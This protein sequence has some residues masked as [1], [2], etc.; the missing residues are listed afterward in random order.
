MEFPE[1]AQMTVY[2]IVAGVRVPFVGPKVFFVETFSGEKGLRVPNARWRQAPR[3]MLEKCAE[4]AALR[5][6]FP[7]ELA[8]E[9]TAEEMAGQVL[10]ADSAVQAIY[11]EVNT[12]AGDA[13]GGDQA[14][15]GQQQGGGAEPED[16]RDLNGWH[17]KR[18][19]AYMESMRKGLPTIETLADL[20][21][22]L[23]VDADKIASLPAEEAKEAEDLI[24]IERER[25]EKLPVQQDNGLATDEARDE[26]DHSDEPPID[27]N[28]ADDDR[29]DDEPQGDGTTDGTDEGTPATEE[30]DEEEPPFV[31]NF[32]RRVAEVE[33][34]VDLAAL[35]RSEKRAIDAQPGGV[36]R[37]CDRIIAERR[38]ALK[39]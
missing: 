13:G 33:L 1:Y 5:R 31:R 32:R 3:G 22:V 28:Q 9:L 16:E 26:R 19:H 6:A 2:K 24:A 15:G 20:E 7:E 14:Q 34:V 10:Q 11:S 35:E 23:E 17:P 30:Q 4:A 8:G 25:L 36:A 29:E 38:A 21:H 39:G 18:L 12:D 27:D 37:A